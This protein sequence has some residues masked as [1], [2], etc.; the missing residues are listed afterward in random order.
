MAEDVLCLAG[1]VEGVQYRKQKAVEQGSGIPDFTFL[2]PQNSILY[3][4]VKFPLDNY[5]RTSTPTPSSSRP[6][7]GT[8]S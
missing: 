7:S 5:L 1:F 3:M 6:A 8:T 2:L 4:D